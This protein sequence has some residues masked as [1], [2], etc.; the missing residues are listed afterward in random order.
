ML[1]CF[2]GLGSNL[3]EPLLQLKQALSALNRLEHCKL[4]LVSPFYRN[5]ALGPAGAQPDYIN[6]VA[7]LFTSLSATTL[8]GEMQNIENAQGRVRSE[9]WAA[10]TLDL[11]LL[12]YGDQAIATPTLEIPHPRLRERNFVLYPL[13]AIA[14][15]LILPDGTSLSA[16]LDCCSAVGLQQ[17]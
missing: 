3:A 16:L 8:L 14:P 1:R 17:L 2:L 11:D 5:P 12:L 15:E 10:R 9:R 7:E 13:H 4:G 6:A